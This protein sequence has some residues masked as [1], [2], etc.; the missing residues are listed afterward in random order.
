MA[1]RS[2][3]HGR[4]PSTLTPLTACLAILACLIWAG[5]YVTAKTAIGGPGAPGFGAFRTAFTRFAIAGTLLAL[6]GLWRDPSSMLI[7]RED[8]PALG[9]LALLGLC[10]TYTLNYLGLSLSTSTAAALIVP[11]EPVWIALLA[12]LFLRERVTPQRLLGIGCGI[13]GAVLVVLSTR[14][15][16]AAPGVSGMGSA[17]L[18]NVLMVFSLL[19]ESIGILTAKRLTARYKGRAIVTY[20]FLL[21]AVLLAPFAA[22]EWHRDGPAA[23]APAAWAAFAYL[24][25]AC[26][27]GAYPLWFRLLETTDASD[28]TVF[29]FFQP[30]L[31]TLLGVL[32][33][34]DSFTPL[35]LVGA[36]LVLSGTFGVLRRAA[37]T[38]RIAPRAAPEIGRLVR[39]ADH[40]PD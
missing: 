6:W 25:F 35:T 7:A 13:T 11:T 12:V 40:M 24:L 15:P 1:A 19:F 20:E 14:R 28:L 37:G 39:D 21:G 5:A 26:T 4:T 30:V 29:L 16:D 36:A 18:G 10:L 27:L 9:R 31:G 3:S 23:P 34:G 33:K 22:W 32:W 17:M 2:T 38:P 8:W